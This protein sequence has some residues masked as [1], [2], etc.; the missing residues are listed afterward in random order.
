MKVCSN[1]Y[2]Q[3]IQLFKFSVFHL[4]RQQR[5]LDFTLKVVGG[6]ISSLPGIS[7]AIEV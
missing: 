4:F 1:M 3:Q 7:D 5:D 2:K 6:D